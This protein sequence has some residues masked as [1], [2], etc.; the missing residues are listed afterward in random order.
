MSLSINAS[1]KSAITTQTT[2]KSSIREVYMKRKEML[3][4]RIE[5]INKGK[6]DDKTKQEKVKGI[7]AQIAEL[8][9]QMV[10]AEVAEQKK[11]IEEEKKNAEEKAEKNE[12]QKVENQST[13]GVIVSDSM[14]NLISANHNLKD[15]KDLKKLRTDIKGKM[16]VAQEEINSNNGRGSVKYQVNEIGQGTS[17]LY[18]IA[19]QMS[20][21]AYDVKGNVNKAVRDGI[22]QKE[23]LRKAE[24]KDATINDVKASDVNITSD[25]S[26]NISDAKESKANKEI[27]ARA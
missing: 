12:Q 26:D 4:K 11:K 6:D 17:A 16:N 13:N 8:D 22:K 7:Q 24:D 23:I 14:N 27:D 21:K 15:Y 2:K 18:G 19:Q 20:D 25:N 1:L 3:Y 9:K 10:Q 5:N